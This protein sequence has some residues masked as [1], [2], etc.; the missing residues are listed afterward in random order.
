[1][2]ITQLIRNMNKESESKKACFDIAYSYFVIT[3][4]L[5]LI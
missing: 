1:M 4:F 3:Y 5:F 2:F